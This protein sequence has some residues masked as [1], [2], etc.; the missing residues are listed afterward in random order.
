MWTIILL[1]GGA[2]LPITGGAAE[3]SRA[4]H[5]AP[6]WQLQ[7]VERS[8]PVDFYAAT[9][10]YATVLFFWATWCPYCRVLL[11]D[12]EAVREEFVDKPVKF[13]ALNVW[14]DGD[15]KSY[16]RKHGFGFELLLNADGVA[17][18]YGVKGTPGVWL[19]DENK[20]VKYVRL[21]GDK[22]AAV[23]RALRTEL[24]A[25]YPD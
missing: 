5:E 11:P 21:S 9:E 15:P 17:E 25:L 1:L 22:P 19:I 10:G 18:Q 23:A 4:A 3:G 24:K 16:L 2:C 20:Q 8:P 12:L 6:N 7:G 14:E 13:Y